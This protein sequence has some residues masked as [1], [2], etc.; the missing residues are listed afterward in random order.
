MKRL[1]REISMKW[2]LVDVIFMAADNTRLSD[3]RRVQSGIPRTESMARL[4][5]M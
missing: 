4:M 1:S 3:K 2:E 5:Q